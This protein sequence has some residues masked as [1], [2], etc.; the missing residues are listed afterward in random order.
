LLSLFLADES[1]GERRV[2]Q[3]RGY[4]LF[5]LSVLLL[6]KYLLK[7]AEEELGLSVHYVHTEYL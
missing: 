2:C 3:W 6:M 5:P 1:G 7:A 4:G